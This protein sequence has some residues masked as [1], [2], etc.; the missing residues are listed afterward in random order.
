MLETKRLKL[1]FRSIFI[2]F[3]VLL[4]IFIIGFSNVVTCNEIKKEITGKCYYE[5]L[6]L[7]KDASKQEIKKQYR[8]LVVLNYNIRIEIVNFE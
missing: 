3:Q 8:R 6:G 5:I 2:L 4:L 7:T 1:V